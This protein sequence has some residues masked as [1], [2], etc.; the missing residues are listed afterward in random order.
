[1]YRWS[2]FFGSSYDKKPNERKWMGFKLEF[3]LEFQFQFQFQLE[4]ITA[5]E[6]SKS[7]DLED[8]NSLDTTGWLQ[9]CSA[10]GKVMYSIESNAQRGRKLNYK[11]K[12]EFFQSHKKKPLTLTAHRFWSSQLWIGRFC[13]IHHPRTLPRK[14]AKRK[15]LCVIPTILKIH[16]F[17]WFLP[18]RTSA[19]SPAQRHK[20]DRLGRTTRSIAIQIRCESSRWICR[21]PTYQQ[22]DGI[23]QSQE[24]DSFRQSNESTSARTRSRNLGSAAS[25]PTTDPRTKT[26]GKQTAIFMIYKF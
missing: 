20:R 13:R 15:N 1:M 12:I 11:T 8:S 4:S 3:W 23:I 26:K 17:D 16:A 25:A 21:N 22:Q 5:M 2:F 24:Q 6:F 14:A 9:S 18:M 7:V 10:H 19:R